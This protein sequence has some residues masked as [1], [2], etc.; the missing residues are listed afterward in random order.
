M[1]KKALG[2]YRK[3]KVTTSSPIQRVVMVYSA[4]NQKLTEAIQAYE[5]KTPAKFET[6]NNSIQFAE[7]LIHELQTALDKDSDGGEL[8]NRL[9]GLY[10]FWIN[11]LSKANR[12]KDVSKLIEV[13]KMVNEL[14]NS[15]SE[16]ERQF[17]NGEID[18][19]GE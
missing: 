13:Q 6:I 5:E 9:D 10:T 4:I 11:H 19:N 3:V 17:R 14:Y 7:K 18:N 8:A 1:S 12:E 15:W 2:Y 16:V